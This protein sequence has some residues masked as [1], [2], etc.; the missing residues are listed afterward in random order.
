MGKGGKR[1]VRYEEGECKLCGETRQLKRSH[2]IPKFVYKMLRGE[3]GASSVAVSNGVKEE[4][5][6][7]ET[8]P[9]LCG[10]C[11]G[12]LGKWETPASWLVKRAGWEL[13]EEDVGL[14]PPRP[15]GAWVTF[16]RYPE[17]KLFAL[18]YIWRAHH[19]SLATYSQF[20]L[21]A[22][23]LADI[24]E[25]LEKT[26]DAA[27]KAPLDATQTSLLVENIHLETKVDESPA[28]EEK[29]AKARAAKCWVRA[30][31][32]GSWPRAARVARSS[33]ALNA[34][35]ASRQSVAR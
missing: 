29:R 8:E 26:K 3:D 7:G 19:S 34:S 28:A 22:E 23:A 31:W 32:R 15:N 5:H 21:P 4:A 1:P 35:S 16:N 27:G 24:E 17:I 11:E 30:S 10:R 18:S 14:S 25:M 33:P 20:T 12:L 2:I 13:M 9:M 6:G